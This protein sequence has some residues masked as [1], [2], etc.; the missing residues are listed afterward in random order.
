MGAT[1]IAPVC[2]RSVAAA[3]LAASPVFLT[4]AATL[5]YL[6]DFTGSNGTIAQ[7]NNITLTAATTATINVGDVAGV[8]T[9]NTVAFGTLTASTTSGFTFTGS[10]GYKQ[11]YTGLNLSTSNTGQT[12]LNPTTATVSINGPVN[13]QMPRR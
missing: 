5:N 3:A 4:A 13:N 12:I 2:Y 1:T 6:N 10:N 8:N 7:G 11:S 9:G